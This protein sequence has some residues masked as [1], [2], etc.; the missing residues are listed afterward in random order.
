MVWVVL[1]FTISSKSNSVR[2]VFEF[3][4]RTDKITSRFKSRPSNFI[5]KR[6]MY[7]AVAYIIRGLGGRNLSI[8]KCPCAL[9]ALRIRKICN[10][11]LTKVSHKI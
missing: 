6:R 1:E 11:C 5:H 10:I 2:G 3:R 8:K 4:R 7:Y 9:L